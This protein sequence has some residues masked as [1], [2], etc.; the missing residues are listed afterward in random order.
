MS[1]A[2]DRKT[3]TVEV[4]LASIHARG[5]GVELGYEVPQPRRMRDTVLNGYVSLLIAGAPAKTDLNQY[6]GRYRLTLEP[7]DD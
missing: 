6:A 5:N 2:N 7:I 3:M 4:D 1:R